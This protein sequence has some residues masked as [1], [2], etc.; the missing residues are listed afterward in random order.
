MAE[1]YKNI[2]GWFDYEDFYEFIVN[3]FDKGVF[4]EIGTWKGRSTKF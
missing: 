4:V 1:F 3:D 2:Q